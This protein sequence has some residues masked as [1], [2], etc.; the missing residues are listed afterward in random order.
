MKYIRMPA[1]FIILIFCFAISLIAVAEIPRES[2]RKHM[3]ES[4]EMLC[5]KKVF[6]NMIDDVD[7]SKIDRYADSILLGI[8]WQ[9]DSANPL[10]SV[11]ESSYYNDRVKN[12]ND[13]LLTAVEE[14][15]GANKQYLRYWHGSI[16]IVR[17]LLMVMSLK[18][19]YIT[20][21]ICL[22]LL[23]A[24]L[25]IMLMKRK[26]VVPVAGFVTALVL[27]S[28]WFVPM[29]L[30]YTWTYLLMMIFSILILV[31]AKREMRDRYLAAFLAFGM[32]TCFMDFLTTETL[33]L[34]VPLLL[35]VWADKENKGVAFPIKA[36]VSWLVGYAFTWFSK[37]LIASLVLGENVMPYVSE[38]IAERIGGGVGASFGPIKY[39]IYSVVLNIK[40]IF[41]FEYGIIGTFSGFLIIFI[42]IY[43]IYVYREKNADRTR[44][45]IYLMIAIVPYI[46]YLVLHNHSFKHCF[47]TYRAQ[48][49]MI[50]ALAM[51]SEEFKVWNYIRRKHGHRK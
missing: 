40:C 35:L 42:Y 45:A 28:A 23:T 4:A 21:G 51:I 16:A 25:I 37:W 43:I 27:T 31:L 50:L 20:N 11:M 2:I 3:Q 44:I 18:G 47:F 10:K 17:P 38:H 24:V 22:L 8:A 39:M 12:E 32:I 41:P 9:Y 14:N 46:R 13:N 7:G 19:I 15:A 36:A 49:A 6:F 29:S 1:I 48:F 5:D 26:G 33:T 30:E 34:T